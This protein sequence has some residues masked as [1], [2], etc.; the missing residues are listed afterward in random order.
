MNGEVRKRRVLRWQLVPGA[1]LLLLMLVTG[2][3]P[4]ARA[5][6][7]SY[8]LGTT[9]PRGRQAQST[10]TVAW[11]KT[12]GGSYYE[13]AYFIQPTNDGGYIVVGSTSSFGA[14][15]DDVWVLKLDANGNVQW[16]KAYGGSDSDLGWA[17]QQTSDGGY[18]VVGESASFGPYADVWVL[19]LDANGHVQWQKTYG[20]GNYE[21]GWAIQQTSD[22]GYIVLGQTAT[23]GIG[24]LDVWVL[25]LDANGNIQWQKTYGGSD[26]DRGRA[27][28]QTSDG[29]Y[30]VVGSTYSF[31]VGRRDAWVLKLDANGNIQWQ[32]TY[33]GGG[34]DYG[35]AVQQTSDG[36]YIVSGASDSFGANTDAWVLKLDAN[37][38]IQW[39]KTY[40]GSSSE[41]GN[42]IRQTSDGGYVMAGFTYSFGAGNVD[43]WVIKLDAA[44]NVQWQKTYGGSGREVGNIIQLTADGGYIVA[45]DTSSF[46]VDDMWVLKLDANGSISGCGLIGTSSVTVQNTSATVTVPYVG[47][48]NTF[49]SVQ[50]TN[51]T[52]TTTTVSP[53][54]QCFVGP[55]TPTP[56][57]TSTPTSSPTP[58]PT[59]APGTPTPT[60][61][62]TS[63][64]TATPTP[65][66]TPSPTPVRNYRFWGRVEDMSGKPMGDVR[67]DLLGY[68]TRT[69][70]WDLLKQARTHGNGQFFLFWWEDKGYYRYRLQVRPPG[71]WVSVRAEAPLP[72]RVI[73]A[74]TIEYISPASGYYVDNLFVLGRPTPTPTATPT[75]TSTPTPTPTPTL[76]PTPTA[77]ATATPATGVVEGYVWA[78][79]DRD[80][81]RDA[82]EEGVVGL[83]V[84]LESALG[85]GRLAEVRETVTDAQGYFRFVDVMPG[86]YTV[87][88]A[89]P[90]G[91]YV[92]SALTV[93]VEVAAN[94]VV[95]V[96]FA[97][98][99]LPRQHYLPAVIR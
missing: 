49:A 12:Y 2:T 56:S 36:G 91:V 14:G 78:D 97:L 58:T 73:D 46:G 63:P 76:T 55:P 52:V 21:G 17:I 27:I 28:Q 83:R 25:K 4:A 62:P 38:N 70:G 88:V 5:G 43:T 95:D 13:D 69:A 16:Q 71:G 92:V 54:E 6:M 32:K 50:N 79:V 90:G 82:G 39:Q 75:A 33:G 7:A 48:V 29:G 60:P 35:S 77:T 11:A 42:S 1:L 57:P 22:G 89:Y 15:S 74:G 10:A 61:T 18:I 94:T 37:G 41:W 96:G 47:V 8:D 72:G 93:E 87:S 26:N 23:F 59:F 24:A 64:P 99:P 45:G 20:G 31:G 51:A 98:Y 44:G 30:V 81:E 19:K 34:W 53:A 80:G 86:R 65:T 3:M 67:V 68:N 9:K 85:W 66:V 84:R 40:G